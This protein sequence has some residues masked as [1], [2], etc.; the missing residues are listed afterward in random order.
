MALVDIQ[1]ELPPVSDIALEIAW[2]AHARGALDAVPDLQ[3][4][5][6]RVHRHLE[7]G[8]IAEE[9]GPGG[10]TDLHP[11]YPLV[12]LH[13]ASLILPGEK[14]SQPGVHA[15]PQ[16]GFPADRVPTIFPQDRVRTLP[17][18]PTGEEPRTQLEQLA[19]ADAARMLYLAEHDKQARRTLWTAGAVA[20]AGY[21][22]GDM[23]NPWDL[24]VYTLWEKL[25]ED[26]NHFEGIHPRMVGALS[27]YGWA[28]ARLIPPEGVPLK[29]SSRRKNAATHYLFWTEIERDRERFLDVHASLSDSS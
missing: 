6:G 13:A 17:K 1:Q 27:V 25:E 7:V 28:N 2:M 26:L 24:R 8:R 16:N 21:F 9:V 4:L 22:R 29:Q 12:V 5:E 18:R 14:W 19:L 3:M 23:K 11:A 20:A 15:N 10:R